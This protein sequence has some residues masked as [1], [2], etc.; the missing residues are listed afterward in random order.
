MVGDWGPLPLP[1]TAEAA[2]GLS[3]PRYAALYRPLVFLM[4]RLLRPPVIRT[5]SY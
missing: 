2:V 3:L 5:Y 4:D 1:G